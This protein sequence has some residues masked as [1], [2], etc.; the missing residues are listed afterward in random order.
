MKIEKISKE[1]FDEIKINPVIL[2]CSRLK[3]GE[4]FGVIGWNKKTPIPQYIY[5][6][7]RKNKILFA[8]KFETK[9][10]NAGD[11]TGFAIK[12]IK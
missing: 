4:S 6:Y 12:R 3:I 10:M 1:K 7:Q 2:E 9:T 8:K 5:S 11:L